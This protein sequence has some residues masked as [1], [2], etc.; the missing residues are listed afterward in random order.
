MHHGGVLRSL[1]LGLA[2]FLAMGGTSAQAATSSSRGAPSATAPTTA[3]SAL[4]TGPLLPVGKQCGLLGGLR[5]SGNPAVQGLCLYTAYLHCQAATLVYL[6]AG[7]D[8]GAYHYLTVQSAGLYC[9]VT[10]RVVPY[11]VV[12]LPQHTYQCQGLLFLPTTG[13]VGGLIAQQCDSEGDFSIPYA[14][15]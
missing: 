12:A 7:V 6:V 11:G 15:T 14:F 8:T 2:L 13:P 4:A 3:R 1:A 9:A 10:D 5:K